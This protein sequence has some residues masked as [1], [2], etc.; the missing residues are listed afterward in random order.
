MMR[1]F[2][3]KSAIA[4][5]SGLF[6]GVGVILACAG[7]WYTI[8]DS[9][10]YTPELYVDSAYSPFLYSLNEFYYTG[11]DEDYNRKFSKEIV[12]DWYVYLDKKVSEEEIRT[13]LFKTTH[14][15]IDSLKSGKIPI[16]LAGT[17][18]AMSGD[19]KAKEFI[20]Y[21]SFAK[22]AEEFSVVDYDYWT[23]G[24]KPKK[25]N[26]SIGAFCKSVDKAYNA[27][28]DD[29]VKQRYLFQLVRAYYFQQ[30]YITPVTVF[31]KEMQAA[32]KNA[33]YYRTL[34]YVAGSVKKS[35]KIAKAN[36]YYSLVYN[37]NDI[38]KTTAHF[39]F[40]PQNESDFQQTLAMCQTNDE[41]VRSGKCWE[42]S[43]K[44]K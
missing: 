8:E 26:P 6:G 36:Y 32:K 13:I 14:K 42:Y 12:K 21:L 9:T 17:K 16:M 1:T 40:R 35:G 10:N 31:E 25:E 20:N 19:K 2:S 37:G 18:I 3:K 15:S 7:G 27:C 38:L 44:M 33:M 5:I 24:E 23:Y 29:F 22:K 34:S 41:N 28:K 11:Y 30:D 4:L 43:I 39:S